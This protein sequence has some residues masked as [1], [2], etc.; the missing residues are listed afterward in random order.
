M[1][2]SRTAERQVRRPPF[3][4]PHV[5]V[6]AVIDGGDPSAVYRL[7]RP[8]IIIGRGEDAIVAIEDDDEISKRHCRIRVDGSACTLIDLGSLNGTRLN[9]RPLREGVAQRLRHLD[10][11]QVGDTHL[12]FISGRFSRRPGA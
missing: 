6:L 2:E 11:I 8:E 10:E 3:A 4:A 12:L 1:A 5:F 9:C 7:D